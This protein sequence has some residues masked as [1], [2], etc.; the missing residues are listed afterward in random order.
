[1]CGVAGFVARYLRGEARAPSLAHALAEHSTH[2]VPDP[3]GVWADPDGCGGAGHRRLSTINLSVAGRQP[4][5]SASQRIVGTDAGVLAAAVVEA[6]NM[7]LEAQRSWGNAARRSTHANFPLESVAD[8]CLC[9]YAGLM[10]SV[11]P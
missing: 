11:V 2:R 3:E 8:R 4:M 1:M 9:L 6:L 7:P 10:V 5:A